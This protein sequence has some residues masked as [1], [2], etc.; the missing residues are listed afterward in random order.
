MFYMGALS[1]EQQVAVNAILGFA[2]D[3][4]EYMLP[5]LPYLVGLVFVFA[6]L[7]KFTLGAVK[8]V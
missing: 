2:R 1:N 8:R 6:L 5:I 4:L 3:F 7:Y